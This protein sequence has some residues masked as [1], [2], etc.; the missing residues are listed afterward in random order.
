MYFPTPSSP[1]STADAA[2]SD[3]QPKRPNAAHATHQPRP[4]RTR[5]HGSP[6]ASTRTAPHPQRHRMA[7][8]TRKSNNPE[9]KANPRGHTF[10]PNH[11]KRVQVC[12]PRTARQTVS[13][14]TSSDVR[15]HARQEPQQQGGQ[16]RAKA[17]PQESRYFCGREAQRV[18][19]DNACERHTRGAQEVSA[20]RPK[21]GERIAPEAAGQAGAKAANTP[22]RFLCGRAA[23]Q[24]HDR[25]CESTPREKCEVGKPARGAAAESLP[26]GSRRGAQRSRRACLTFFFRK[27][28]TQP[29][30][31]RKT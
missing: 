20:S 13:V 24:A 30:S 2:H 18:L 23:A 4:N 21:N 22:A 7:H 10:N 1:A 5:H 31:R 28:E 15:S 9:A 8:T 25:T 6:A 14:V 16:P 11:K 3:G 27:K 26:Q 19:R 17:G 12:A 29:G